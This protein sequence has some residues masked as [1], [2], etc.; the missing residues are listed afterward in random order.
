[1]KTIRIAI[2]V[3]LLKCGFKLLPK[4]AIDTLLELSGWFWEDYLEKSEGK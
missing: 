1:M 3:V 4:D 2:A